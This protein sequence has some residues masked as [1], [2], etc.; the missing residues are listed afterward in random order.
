MSNI[1]ELRAAKIPRI[2]WLAVHYWFVI[3]ENDNIQRWEVWQ[4]QNVGGEENWGHLYF[5]LMPFDRGVGNGESWVEKQW[6]G[7]LAEN[8]IIII[9]QTPIDYPH[10]YLYRYY[11]GPNSNTYVQWILD[12]AGIDH[13]LSKKGW[14][15]Y[16][17]RFF[18]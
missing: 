18:S 15:K 14:G 2:G 3:K 10:N 13:Q 9:R 12:R 17:D 8:L 5:N 1:V 11:P 6:D 16:Y 4:S 7:D